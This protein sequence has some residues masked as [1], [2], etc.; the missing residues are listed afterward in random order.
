MYDKNLFAVEPEFWIWS[1]KNYY[2]NSYAPQDL[3]YMYI[4]QFL[5]DSLPAFDC[6][7]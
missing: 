5:E 1:L 2:V 7:I 6:F 3:R 4:Q